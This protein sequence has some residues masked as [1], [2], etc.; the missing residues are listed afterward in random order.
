MDPV[1]LIEAAKQMETI[2]K[3]IVGDGLKAAVATIMGDIHME[4]AM[5]A[6]EI[7]NIDSAI[8]HLETAHVAYLTIWKKDGLLKAVKTGFNFAEMWEA[9]QK[10]AWA[11]CLMALCYAG[12]GEPQKAMKI[13]TLAEKAI[14]YFGWQWQDGIFGNAQ[15]AVASLIAIPFLLVNPKNVAFGT[16]R[17]L[18]NRDQFTELKST[19]ERA[20][21][22]KRLTG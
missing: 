11:C 20:I 5:L 17:T 16:L 1:S 3:F 22:N 13:L 10:D 18:I 19:L 14:K 12:L 2:K 9:N 7:G 8:T 6:L 4:A 21:S 15:D